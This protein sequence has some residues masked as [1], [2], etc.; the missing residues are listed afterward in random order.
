[1]LFFTVTSYL[2]KDKVNRSV[3]YY[4]WRFTDEVKEVVENAACYE[5]FKDYYAYG[6]TMLFSKCLVQI[7]IASHL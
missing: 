6:V 2:P 4:P 5:R 1:M 3:L 7:L